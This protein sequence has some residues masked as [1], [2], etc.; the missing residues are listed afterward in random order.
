[1]NGVRNAIVAQ[2]EAEICKLKMEAGSVQFTLEERKK[3][4]QK[5]ARL[6]RE[7]DSWIG[8]NQWT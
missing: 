4:K 2:L 7:R 3:K 6:K 1:M 8:R 5:L